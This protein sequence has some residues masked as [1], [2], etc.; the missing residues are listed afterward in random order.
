MNE[1][2]GYGFKR[3]AGTNNYVLTG[4][5]LSG[6]SI[7]IEGLTKIEVRYKLNR[8]TGKYEINTMFPIE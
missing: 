2:I 7:K 5:R 8:N 6:E 4:Q 3:P 1:P